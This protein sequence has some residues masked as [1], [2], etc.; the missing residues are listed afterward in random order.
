MS[1]PSAR[2]AER[3][4]RD[5][6]DVESP[7]LLDRLRA[8]SDPFGHEVSERVHAAVVLAAGGDIDRFERL[9]REAE[10]DWRDVLV[11]AGLAHEGWPDIVAEQLGPG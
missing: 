9:A 10:M 4:R 11:I 8:I 2:V 6:G 7:A 3:V 5:F 1:E